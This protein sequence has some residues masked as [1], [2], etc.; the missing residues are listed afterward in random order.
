LESIKEIDDT[1]S[2]LIAL[3]IPKRN[4]VRNAIDCKDR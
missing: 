2:L 1:L 4:R 3:L